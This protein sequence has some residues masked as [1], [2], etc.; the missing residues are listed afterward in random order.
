MVDEPSDRIPTPRPTRRKPRSGEVLH[1]TRSASVQFLR[2][3]FV[4]HSRSLTHKIDTTNAD[5]LD[6]RVGKS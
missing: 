4:R 3:I 1:L 6:E 5:L 2:P